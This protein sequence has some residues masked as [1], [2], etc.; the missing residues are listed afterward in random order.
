MYLVRWHRFYK[1]YFDLI[2][3]NELNKRNVISDHEY[4]IKT[5]PSSY[6]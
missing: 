1:G 4:V 5:V 6:I 3:V 2:K